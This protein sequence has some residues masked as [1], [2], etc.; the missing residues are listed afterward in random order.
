MERAAKKEV[1]HSFEPFKNIRVLAIDD[2]PPIC[3][4]D[5]ER[6]SFLIGVLWRNGTIEGVLSTKVNWDG[7]DAT[8]KITEM[9]RTSRFSNQI[10]SI[11]IN[12]VTVAGL[13]IINISLLSQSLKIPA[14]AITRHP[15]SV[16]KLE[17]AVQKL[18][19][20]S[21]SDSLIYSKLSNLNNA[22]EPIPV[23]TKPKT[24]IQFSG[25]N[26]FDAAKLVK[27]VGLEPLRISHLFASG[28]SGESK[29]RF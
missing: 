14:I 15:P 17:N 28:L 29:G 27:A 23:N 13:N 9:I 8:E 16:K 3:N 18:K 22:G 6:Q 5:F 7:N 20:K 24:Y 26:K 21:F 25:I 19:E 1:K 10:Q 2:S 4:K 11:F 12:S